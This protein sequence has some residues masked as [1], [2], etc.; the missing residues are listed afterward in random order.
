MED[1]IHDECGVFGIYKNDERDIVDETY[2]ALY[3]LQHRGT[4]GAG[5]CVNDGGTMTVCKGFGVVP[6]ALTEKELAHL[7]GGNIAI[8]HVRHATTDAADRAALQPLLMRYICGQIS[9]TLNGA[10]ANYNELREEL[11]QG[12]AIFQ[13]NSDIEVIAYMIAK[14]RLASSSIEEA[15]L[16][17]M[18]EISGSYSIVMMAPSRLIGVRDPRGFRPLC[19]GK[20]GESYIITSE[21]CVF[22]SLGGEFIRDVEPGEMVVVDSEGLHSYKD[23]CSKENSLCMFEFI[24]FARP[25][26]VID[27]V[28]VT[29]ARQRAGVQ[30]AKEH[31]VEADMVCAVPDCG[32]DAAIGYAQ[33]SGIQYGVGLIKNRYIGRAYNRRKKTAEHTMR[34]KLNALKASVKDKRIVLID[35]SLVKGETSKHIVRLLKDAGAKEVHLRISSP[36]L[37]Y[38]CFYGASMKSKDELAASHFSIEEIRQ[39]IGADSLEFLSMESLH[40]IA[41]ECKI[42]FCDACFSGNYPLEVTETSHEDKYQRKL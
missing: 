9:L 29:I 41:D 5:I 2:L 39:K 1:K 10:L 6:E 18:K 3:A 30:L 38:P 11:H 16:K 8:G 35:D 40:K 32:I 19:I 26:S 37:K 31:P 15:V 12:G 20:L 24:Y 42:G 28:S 23:N 33:E 22:D 34:I 25:D 14:A 27:G 36:P 21:S 7:G 13:S 4:V 17:A